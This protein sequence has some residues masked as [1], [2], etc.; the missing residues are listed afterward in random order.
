MIIRFDHLQRYEHCLAI[1]RSIYNE[2]QCRI[3]RGLY[4]P[5]TMSLHAIDWDRDPFDIFLGT[6][7]DAF[8]RSTYVPGDA[9]QFSAE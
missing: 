2:R 1:V 9:M 4:T 6:S 7:T 8:C 3:A 5:A